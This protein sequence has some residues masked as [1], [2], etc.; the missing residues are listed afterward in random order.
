MPTPPTVVP[1]PPATEALASVHTSTFTTLLERLGISVLVSTYQAGKLIV[2]RADGGRVNTH[3]R[4]FPVP[5]GLA[6][7]GRRLAIGGKNRVY[8]LHDV[9]AVAPKL[10]PAGKHDACL[11][12]RTC[13]FTGD[14]DV[15]ELAWGA[16][17]LWIVNTRF[18][19]LA[20]LSHDF[21][22]VPRWRP[23][24]VSAL[25]PEDR[26]HLNGLAI[27]N[28]QPHFAT[29]LG[30]TDANEAWRKDKARG[31]CLLEV[32]TGQAIARGLSMPHSPRWHGGRL[33]LLESGEGALSVVEPATGA[34]RP[35]AKLPGFTRGL[36]FAGQFAFVGLSQVRET[37]MF[38]GI[39]ITERAAERTCG[40]WVVDVTNGQVVAFLRFDSGVQEV[41]AVQILPR[42]QYPEVFNETDERYLGSS[43]V[44]PEEALAQVAFKDSQK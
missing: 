36:D 9:P 26:C 25:S 7:D 44:L 10:E 41:F 34:V 38:S 18:S 27:V 28:G 4:D 13:H 40:V 3:F 22:F 2:L 6:W 43:Y 30:M 31:G 12:P 23:P 35:I 20:T 33:F 19:C 11:L 24:F 32:A 29:A 16:E 17:G 39:P 1:P 42:I 8:E 15:H 5:M 14:I 37:A 21:S